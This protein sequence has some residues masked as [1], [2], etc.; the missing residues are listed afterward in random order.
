MVGMHARRTV[1][2]LMAAVC[3]YVAAASIAANGAET[4]PG[5]AT[6]P[7]QAQNDRMAERAQRVGLNVKPGCTAC[8]VT[9]T[10]SVAQGFRVINRVPT[11]QK[12]EVPRTC[13]M[14]NDD[15]TTAFR[16]EGTFSLKDEIQG[17]PPAFGAVKVVK[18]VESARDGDA[19]YR[20]LVDL[21]LAARSN[22]A[23]L[24][25]VVGPAEAKVV[26]DDYCFIGPITEAERAHVK[27]LVVLL[28][29]R[30]VAQWSPAEREELSKSNNPWI[31]ALAE[32]KR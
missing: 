7:N 1:V 14:V 15:G 5:A 29:A 21:V 3:G 4:M 2:G 13:V 31:R 26:P 18:R 24:F 10:S 16:I 23:G 6:E 19:A 8:I 32:L 22:R 28:A 27:E 17:K 20:N 30:P 12:V 11:T 9:F 25:L